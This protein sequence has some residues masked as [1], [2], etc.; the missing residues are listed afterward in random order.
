[1]LRICYPALSWISIE[2]FALFFNLFVISRF[3]GSIF[4]QWPVDCQAKPVPPSLC[5]L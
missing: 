4:K 1:M 2:V 5:S 3:A